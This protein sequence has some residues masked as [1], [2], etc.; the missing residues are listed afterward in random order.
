M[1]SKI[2]GVELGLL[3]T[4]ALKMCN[5]Y[6]SNLQNLPKAIHPLYYKHSSIKKTPFVALWRC[7][8]FSVNFAENPF[9]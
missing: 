2:S 9:D 7:L 4:N 3:M 1:D 5:K 6:L 8:I